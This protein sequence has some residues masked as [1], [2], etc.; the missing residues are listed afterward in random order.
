MGAALGRAHFCGVRRDAAKTRQTAALGLW[1]SALLSPPRERVSLSDEAS[2]AEPGRTHGINC[3][4][5]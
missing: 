3:Y 5:C 1:D 4:Y 2:S